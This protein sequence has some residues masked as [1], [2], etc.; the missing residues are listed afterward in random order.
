MGWAIGAC[1]RGDRADDRRIGTCGL[2]DAAADRVQEIPV[3]MLDAAICRPLRRQQA[4]PSEPWEH[5]R[6]DLDRQEH[7]KRRLSG[8]LRLG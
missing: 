5:G 2:V 3:W 4:T 7:R 8:T 1:P 6:A